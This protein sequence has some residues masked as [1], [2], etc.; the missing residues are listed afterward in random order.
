VHRFE[1]R[2]EAR[3]ELAGHDDAVLPGFHLANSRTTGA[4]VVVGGAN[5]PG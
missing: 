1:S 4:P 3:A 5:S 2:C